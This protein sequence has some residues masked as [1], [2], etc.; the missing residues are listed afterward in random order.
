ME[1]IIELQNL[2]KNYGNKEAVK[3]INLEIKKGELFTLL[4][5]NGAGKTTTLKMLV[6][7]LK[8]TS[9]NITINGIDALKMPIKAKNFISYVP[10]VPYVY[11]KLTPWELVRFVG[12]LY[13]LEPNE[14]KSR[15]EEL[16]KF[17]KI[18]ETRNSLIEEF[19]HG[20]RQKAILTASL[21]H[22]PKVFILDEPMVG[23]DPISMHKFKS[24]LKN[25][26]REGMTVLFSTHTLSTAEEL[27][28]RIGIINRGE[29]IALGTLEELK[30][31]YHSK[32][33]LE[34]M[35]MKLVEE[36]MVKN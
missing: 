4:G 11:D 24:Y 7:L 18:W 8:P 30:E 15:G 19:S 9:G 34:N 27:A 16:L 29:L 6:G 25:E 2:K 28:D 36:G 33:N 31:K 10:D 21:L 35:F 3:S 20:M 22:K 1:N 26:V 32:E 13:D 14:I 12:K 23:L 5:A 17:F